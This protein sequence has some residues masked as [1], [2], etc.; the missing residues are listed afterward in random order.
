MVDDEVPDRIVAATIDVIERLGLEG[1]TTRTIAAAAGVNLA[2]VNY[3]FRSKDKLIETVLEKTMGHAAGD[4]AQILGNGEATPG[5]RLAEFAEHM[6]SGLVRFPKLSLAHFSAKNP[7]PK[8]A[9][10]RSVDALHPQIARVIEA[11]TGLSSGAASIAAIAFMGSI[12]LPVFYGRLFFRR[13]GAGPAIDLQD[14][15]ERRRYI[16]R[17]VAEALSGSG[18]EK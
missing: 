17:V 16:E 9:L 6:L 15:A 3:Y 1:A 10:D 7:G 12:L 13:E 4:W 2:S 5:A 14:E 11:G 18:R 8:A